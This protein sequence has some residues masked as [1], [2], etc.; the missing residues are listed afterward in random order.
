MLSKLTKRQKNWINGS[1]CFI[2][3]GGVM[4]MGILQYNSL[5]KHKAFTYGHVYDLDGLNKSPEVFVYY[6]YTLRGKQYDEM[7]AL[8]NT[9]KSDHLRPLYKLLLNKTFPVAY[10]TTDF[11][12][13]QILI[14][15]I[16]YKRFGYTRPD[17]LASVFRAYDSIVK[18]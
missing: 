11:G 8:P 1:L 15:L 2:L 14:S 7:S 18:N 6:R 5:E 12:S 17:S 4:T 13:A 9:N 16:D 10:D 3:I